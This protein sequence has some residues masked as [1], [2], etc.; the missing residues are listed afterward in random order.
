MFADII[1]IF[2]DNKDFSLFRQGEG[3]IF[4]M[5]ILFQPALHLSA[6]PDQLQKPHLPS[7]GDGRKGGVSMK[8]DDEGWFQTRPYGTPLVG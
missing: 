2:G 6:K 7:V 4:L 3:E 8:S 5:A 1:F